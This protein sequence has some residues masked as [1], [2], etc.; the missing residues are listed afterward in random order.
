MYT[1]VL[2]INTS[3][4]ALHLTCVQFGQISPVVFLGNTKPHVYKQ[5]TDTHRDTHRDTLTDTHRDTQ[6]ET[7]RD[8]LTDTHRDTQR[9][10]DVP[11]LS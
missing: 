11:E 7:H 9:P 6:R 3:H 10:C 1:P 8:T 2:N 4:N 5:L